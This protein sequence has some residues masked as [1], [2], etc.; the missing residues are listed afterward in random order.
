MLTS[1]SE[2][3]LMLQSDNADERLTPLDRE[4][5]Q[6]GKASTK[7]CSR[8]SCLVTLEELLRWLH[9][10][11]GIVDEY[12]M[13]PPV[14]NFRYCILMHCGCVAFVEIAGLFSF[15][16]LQWRANQPGRGR[17][18]KRFLTTLTTRPFKRCRW[19]LER[20][21]KRLDPIAPLGLPGQGQ[22]TSSGE[23]HSEGSHDFS[24][25]TWSSWALVWVLTLTGFG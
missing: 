19:R 10:H 14:V 6:N 18:G 12:D 7:G 4:I 20:D 15:L 13:G 5:G 3:G 8:S 21:C 23:N 2:Y 17:G 11:P 9:V 25:L 1:R 16:P 24:I 22:K